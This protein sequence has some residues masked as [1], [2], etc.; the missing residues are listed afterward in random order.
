MLPFPLLHLYFSPRQ[1]QPCK[2][3]TG[4]PCG[5]LITVGVTPP[6]IISPVETEFGRSRAG[7]LHFCYRAFWSK[8][9]L[10]ASEPCAPPRHLCPV[11]HLGRASARH[12]LAQHFHIPR[13]QIVFPVLFI[14]LYIPTRFLKKSVSRKSLGHGAHLS[15]AKLHDLC[16]NNL[17]GVLQPT[18][19]SN[20]LLV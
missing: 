13:S 7:E 1:G 20:I 8:A 17:M 10:S 5:F 11:G 16:Q 4:E 9:L 3:Q 19:H 6:R 2:T 18:R 12:G 15:R 14:S